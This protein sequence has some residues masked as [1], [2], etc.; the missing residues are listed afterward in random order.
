MDGNI[1]IDGVLASCYPSADHDMAH[2]AMAPMRWYPEVVEM[3]FGEHNGF[4]AYANINEEL[5]KLVTPL[6]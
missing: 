2:I 3:I 1:I 6:V 5:G 4:S